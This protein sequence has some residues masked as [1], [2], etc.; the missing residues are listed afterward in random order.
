MVINH[1]MSSMFANRQ[2]GINNNALLGNIEKLSSGEKIN[3]AGDDAS[4]L[5]VSEKMRS[6]I[7]G[8]NQ[9]NRNVNNG[10]SFIQTTEGYLQETTDILQRI[11]ELSVQSAN[12]IYTEEDRMQIQVEVSQLVAEVDRIASQAQFNGMNMLTGRFAE[13][14]ISGQVMQFH[15]GANMDQRVSAFVGTMS[16]EALGLRSATS[17]QLSISTPDSA[18]IA[19]G[20]IDNALKLV[21]KQRADLGAYQNRLETASKGIAIAAE[22]TQSAESVIRDTDMASAMV[23]YTKNSILTQAST[24]MLAQAN[25]QSQNVLALLQ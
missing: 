12:G 4:G 11:R 7:R 13:N 20:T 1:N 9:A 25:T 23:E 16:A 8:L 22:N 21:N 17:E 2:L 6:Q 24:A 19:I 5:A 3:R 18:N 14:S 15:V 10:I